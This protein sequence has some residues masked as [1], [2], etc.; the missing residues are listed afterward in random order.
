MRGVFYSYCSLALTLVK[1]VSFT[2]EKETQQ[3]ALF[4]GLVSSC[5]NSLAFSL[6]QARA[7]KANAS[8]DIETRF[9]TYYKLL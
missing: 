9:K 4:A 8:K 1:E 6:R 5:Q 7:E 3:C 2:R